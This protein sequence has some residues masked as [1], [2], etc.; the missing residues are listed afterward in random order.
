LHQD[1]LVHHTQLRLAVYQ[2]YM[3]HH[4]QEK[5]R[6][7]HLTVDHKEVTVVNHPTEHILPYLN[8]EGLQLERGNKNG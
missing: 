1:E 6:H 3:S 2:Q 5:E 4:Q 8:I 7:Q